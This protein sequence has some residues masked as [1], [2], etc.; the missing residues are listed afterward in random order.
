MTE[1]DLHDDVA[2]QIAA[3]PLRRHRPLIVSDA[4]EVLVNFMTGFEG[5]LSDRGL[6]FTWESYRLNGNI[7]R[8][9]ADN[10]LERPEIRDL[11][12]AF[13]AECI[14]A[15]TPVEGAAE[16][17]GALSRR[18]QI[19]VLSNVPLAHCH[20]RRRWLARHGIDY[21]LVANIGAKGPAV[22]ELAALAAAPTYFIDDSPQNHLTVARDAGHVHRLHFVADARLARLLGPA[23][24][25]HHRADDWAAARA[26]IEADLAAQGY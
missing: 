14:D 3:V 17:L 10:A 24:E 25:S 1:T 2:N 16:A 6:Y 8:R 4:D 5:F 20:R 22:R 26:L 7:R 9:G 13:F 18:A 11:I 23:P 21:P 12:D 19:V 15:L